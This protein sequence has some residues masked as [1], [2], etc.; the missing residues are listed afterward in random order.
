MTF[1]SNIAPMSWADRRKYGAARIRNAAF[2]EI[3]AL[4][5]KRKS[6]GMKQK[7][8]AKRLDRDTG[9]LSKELRG[10]GNWRLKTIGA[11]VEALDGE[12]EIRVYDIN[13][14]ALSR[15]NNSIAHSGYDIELKD[16]SVKIRMSAGS[17]R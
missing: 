1:Q 3:I 15:E 6:Q 10:P 13:D 7:E 4:W 12:I 17:S 11:M 16:P 14:R 8:F 5:R 9:W 2:A